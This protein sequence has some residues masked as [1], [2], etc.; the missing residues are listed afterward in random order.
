MY[1]CWTIFLSIHFSVLNLLKFLT[2]L[3]ILR[4]DGK[5]GWRALMDGRQEGKKEEMK[6]RKARRKEIIGRKEGRKEKR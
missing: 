6:G 5:K 2:F 4:I 1:G 3:S